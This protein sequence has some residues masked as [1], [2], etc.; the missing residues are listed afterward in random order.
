M[1]QTAQQERRIHVI[2]ATKQAAA[3][4][5]AS[6]RRQRVAAY[7]RVSTDSEEQ[8]TS[9]TA[10]KAYYTQKIDENPDWEMA[11]IFADKGITGT[12]MKK[13]VEF[14]KMI[15]ACKRGKIDLI[16][17]KSLSRFARN[18]VDSL[19]VVRM[20]RANGIGVIFEKEN[21]NTLTESSEFLLTLFSGFAQAESESISKNVIWGIQKSREAGNVPFQ[22]QKLLGYQRG[23]DGQPEIVRSEAEVVKRIYRRYLDGCSLAQIKR[24]LEA[25]GVPTASGIQG[26]T[27]QVV[28]NILTNERYI[29]DALLQKTY[30]TDCISKTVKKNQGDRPMVYVERNHPAIVS[31]AMF[32]QVREEMA[33]RASKRKVMQKTGKTEQG[34]YSAKYALSELLVC[35]ECG[36]PYK[37]CTWA[38]SGKKRIVWRCVSRLEFGTKYCHDSPSM[39][40]DKL[41]QA[42]LEGINEFVQAGQGLGDEL[43]DLASI[44]QQGGSAD[45]IDPLTLRNRLDTLTAQQAELLDKV[46]EDMESEELNAQLKAIMEE[47]QAILGRLGA[48]QQDEEQR[49]GQE[50][51]LRELAEWLKQQKS[52][53]TEYDDTITRRYMERITVVDAETIR[54]KFRYTDVEIDR[55]VRT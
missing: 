22:Y 35:G 23:P 49:A 13:R 8:L 45:G 34:K 14:K 16:L 43:L 5:R 53:F 42:I 18:T 3:P 1:E 11:G 37:R 2:P 27:Y 40:E 52:E 19:E 50:A 46:L 15:A 26:W 38:R 24:E 9:Y 39:D 55:A 54:I 44:V 17:T 12:S 29:G 10:Q 30:T 31:K 36:T 47:K 28:R 6:G 25:D 32:Y 48:I 21:I 4:G 33:R 51:R 20:L 41:H 7:C